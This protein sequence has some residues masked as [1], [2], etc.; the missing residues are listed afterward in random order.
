M[1]KR[2][3]DHSKAMVGGHRPFQGDGR[4]RE[5]EHLGRVL[6][7]RPDGRRARLCT[8]TVLS[9]YYKAIDVKRAIDLREYAD[10]NADRIDVYD[11]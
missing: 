4:Q 7:A 1:I 10:Q 3:Y 8:P 11:D 2:I 5:Y 6:D 9:A